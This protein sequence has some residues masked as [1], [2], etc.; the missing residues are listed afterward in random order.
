MPESIPVE[1][2]APARPFEGPRL[3]EA[4]DSP[5]AV[6]PVLD[7]LL[8]RGPD[9]GAA[10]LA[11][12]AGGSVL[13]G[14]LLR[15]AAAGTAVY[16]LAVGLPGGWLQ[17]GATAVK[18]PLVLLLAGAVSLP[19]TWLATHLAGRPVPF[20]RLAPFALHALATVGLVLAGLAPVVVVAWLSLSGPGASPWWVYRRVVLVGLGVALLAGLV[21]ARRLLRG[22]PPLAGLAAAAAFGL[23]ALQLAWLLRPV[24]GAPGE[25]VLLRPLESN[26]LAEA[27]RALGAAVLR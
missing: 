11:G 14:R 20:A 22:I 27:L 21:G 24:V 19:A 12:R 10:V 25:A 16:G 9:L 2:R 13:T 8:R 18:L 17:A 1:S 15:V 7:A 5:L 3:R 4:G 23:A 26:G 6:E